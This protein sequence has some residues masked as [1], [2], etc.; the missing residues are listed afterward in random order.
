MDKED[1]L[2]M[3]VLLNQCGTVRYVLDLVDCARRMF[4]VVVLGT[5]EIGSSVVVAL[6]QEQVYD[7]P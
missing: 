2:R 4:E 6:L 3:L 1:E 5:F 7:L